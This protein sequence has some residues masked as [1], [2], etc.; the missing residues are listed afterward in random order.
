M[1]EVEDPELFSFSKA[2]QQD[3]FKLSQVSKSNVNN[4]SDFT[5]Y[6]MVE[7]KEISERRVS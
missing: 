4:H 7:I 3:S 1:N 2:R 5:R 6:Q